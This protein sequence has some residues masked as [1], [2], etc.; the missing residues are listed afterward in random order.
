MHAFTLKNDK[1][2]RI[3]YIA[4][5]VINGYVIDFSSVIYYMCNDCVAEQ[6]NVYLEKRVH[7]HFRYSRRKKR[8]MRKRVSPYASAHIVPVSTIP[9]KTSVNLKL[10]NTVR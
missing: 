4:L 6:I 2:I 7:V 1:P 3:V 10:Y 5:I 8:R 9:C